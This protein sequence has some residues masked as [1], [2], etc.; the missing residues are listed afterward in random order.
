MELLYH[1]TNQV[2]LEIRDCF[3]KLGQLKHSNID[4]STLE[5]EIKEKIN[6]VEK[7]CDRLDILVQKE[8]VLKRQSSKLKVDQLKYDNT[9]FQ[10]A[11]AKHKAEKNRKLME[12]RERE[13]LLSRRFTENKA[14]G[15]T[16]IYIDYSVQHQNSLMSANRGVDDL[17]SSGSSIL[18]NL[19]SQKNKLKGAHRR[20]LDLGNTLGLSNTTIRLIERRAREDKYVLIGGIIL[21]LIVMILV[22]MYLI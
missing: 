8:P 13:E 12:Q 17:I 5:D 19:K 6:L 4:T 15:D 11:L 14:S 20:V 9:H 16:A 7:N 3:Q 21:T 1:K 10:S 2:V 22:I 18:D